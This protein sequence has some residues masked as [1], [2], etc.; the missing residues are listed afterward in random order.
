[1]QPQREYACRNHGHREPSQFRNLAQ[2][3]DGE[4]LALQSPG[5]TDQG[6]TGLA[7]KHALAHAVLGSVL[8]ANRAVQGIAE[9]ARALMPDR[10]LAPPTRRSAGG[11]ISSA[12]ARRMVCPGANSQILGVRSQDLHVGAMVAATGPAIAKRP[13]ASVT[14]F[15]HS[16]KAR[17][18]SQMVSARRPATSLYSL[19]VRYAALVTAPCKSAPAM[20]RQRFSCVRTASRSCTDGPSATTIRVGSVTTAKAQ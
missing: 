9:L 2:E 10:N 7:P 18:G 1:M 3:R 20:S 12:A 6:P 8:T 17:V 14:F 5:R 19:R 13:P 16:P 15:K 11:N 4:K